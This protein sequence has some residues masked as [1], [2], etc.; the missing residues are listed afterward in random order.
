M[1][2]CDVFLAARVR[3]KC[4]KDSITCRMFQY[5]CDSLHQLINESHLICQL[6]IMINDTK[7]I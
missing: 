4:K 6:A 3:K 7:L 1:I 5:Q 2:V